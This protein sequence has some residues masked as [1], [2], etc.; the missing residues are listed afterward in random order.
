M[1][2]NKKRWG[3]YLQGKT[4]I[5]LTE[6]DYLTIKNALSNPI[7][8]KSIDKIKVSP[9][10]WHV[11]HGKE[12]LKTKGTMGRHQEAVMKWKDEEEKILA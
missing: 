2:P 6:S 5:L 9:T 7:Y 4:C 8:S 11:E 3:I 1:I 10:K 12:T